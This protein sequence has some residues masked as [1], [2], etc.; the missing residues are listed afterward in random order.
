MRE[1]QTA[2]GKLIHQPLL[3]NVESYNAAISACEKRKHWEEVH[4][5]LQGMVHQWL[6]PLVVSYNAA[7]SACEKGELIIATHCGSLTKEANAAFG[8]LQQ[9]WQQ[10]PEPVGDTY[11]APICPYIAFRA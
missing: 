1:G 6:A 4:G 9:V 8:L 11:N 2:A 5:L 10:G 3:P 7:T